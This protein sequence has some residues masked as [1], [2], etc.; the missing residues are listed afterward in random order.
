MFSELFDHVKCTIKSLFEYFSS[1]LTGQPFFN[2][3]RTISVFIG[4]NE[5][6]KKRGAYRVYS[7]II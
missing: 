3:K 5:Y 4:S 1:H 7:I 2:C 6:K